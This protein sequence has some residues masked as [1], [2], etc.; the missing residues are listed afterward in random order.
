MFNT[1]FLVYSIIQ[2]RGMLSNLR[3]ASIH[4]LLPQILE[5]KDLL[6]TGT[7]RILV[8]LIPV[9]I[10]LTEATYIGTFYWSVPSYL[11]KR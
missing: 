4:L 6:E 10:S 1:L 7:L 2:V 5:I 3:S 11:S 8:W 9:M